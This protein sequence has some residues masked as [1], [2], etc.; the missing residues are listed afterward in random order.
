MK[1]FG[2]VYRNR[3]VF[4]TGHT[5]FKGSWLAAWL[6]Q[7]GATVTG[8][9]LP[10][11]SSP[12][13]WDLLQLPVC[14]LH[15][16]I[17]DA[18]AV[19]EAIQNHQ[20]EIVFHLAAQPLVRHSYRQPLESWSTNVMGTANILEAC[21]GLQGLRAIVIITTDK[22]YSD[23]EWSRA[24]SEN[25]TLGGHDPYSASKAASELVVNSY[26]SAFFFR[27]S[28]PLIATVR[29]GNV[30]G[31]GDWSEDRIIP[32][33]V[34]A[35]NRKASLEI[36]SPEAKRSWQHVLECVSAYLLLGQHLISGRRDLAQPLNIGP[37]PDDAWSVSEVLTALKRYWPE[38]RWHQSEAVQPHETRL[39]YLDSSKARSLLHWRPVWRLD[40]ALA[41]TAAWYQ[42]LSLTDKPMTME[43]L[44]SYLDC[45]VKENHSW[46]AP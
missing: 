44:S 11:S 23:R 13:H 16:D 8:F 35:I 42:K 19:R 46:V 45:A 7:M 25:D 3:R 36:R 26:R 37:G 22:V 27:E 17:R 1:Q 32:D 29:A 31:G 20:P 21:R 2:D 33:V 6:I 10:P 43:Q 15:G 9:A 4:V 39:L 5:G 30:I 12:N 14:D 40:T 28:D 18:G 41:A 38:L 24:Y 34:R